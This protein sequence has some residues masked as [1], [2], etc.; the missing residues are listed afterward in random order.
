MKK[1]KNTT[2]T[3]RGRTFVGQ[4]TSAKMKKTVIVEIERNRY[5]KK[6]ERYEKRRTRIKAHNPEQINAIEGEIVK[7]KETRPIS[8]TKKFTIIEKIEEKQ[9]EEKKK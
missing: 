2:I 6:Y 7:I 4:I 3:T 5:I 8:K 1:P 9:K